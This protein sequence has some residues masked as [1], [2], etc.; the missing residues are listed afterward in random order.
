[1]Q[2]VVGLYKIKQYFAKDLWMRYPLPYFLIDFNAPVGELGTFEYLR[3][4]FVSGERYVPNVD[5]IHF[6]S[7]KD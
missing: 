3:S 6:V 4:S 1:M 2:T 5:S 7:D